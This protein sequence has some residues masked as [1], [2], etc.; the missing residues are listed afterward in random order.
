M[1]PSALLTLLITLIAAVLLISDRVRADLM[2]LIIMVVLGLSGLVTPA[3]TFAGFSGSAVMTILGI[4]IISEGLRQ[5]GV[6]L[7]LGNWMRRLGGKNEIR[8][9]LVTMLVAAGLSLFMNNIAVVG[10]LFPATMAVARRTR[11]PAGKLL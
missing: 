5:T 2:G 1:E 10:V 6:A 8:L 11:V 9:I 7:W 3:E 4:S